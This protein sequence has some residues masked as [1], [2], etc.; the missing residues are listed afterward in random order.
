MYVCYQYDVELLRLQCKPACLIM[1][2][3][4]FDRLKTVFVSMR[5][6]FSEWLG[7]TSVL[8]PYSNELRIGYKYEI[9]NPGEQKT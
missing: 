7:S 5:T 9:C 1:I 3:Q 8:P 2:K 6:L 4:G